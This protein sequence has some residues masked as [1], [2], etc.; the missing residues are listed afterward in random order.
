MGARAY[1]SFAADYPGEPA[2]G[3][4]ETRCLG[5]VL[6]ENGVATLTSKAP[7]AAGQIML[8]FIE[9]RREADRRNHKKVMLLCAFCANE[10]PSPKRCCGCSIRI[11]CGAACQAW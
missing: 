4:A 3:R 8:G 7:A 5:L 1:A 2:L 9:A 10:A 6:H 11:Y